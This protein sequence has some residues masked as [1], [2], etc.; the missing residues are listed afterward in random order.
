MLCRMLAPPATTVPI[1]LNADVPDRA[2]TAAFQAAG[3]AA[4]V[5]IYL[6]CLRP[7]DRGCDWG[8]R[9]GGGPRVA[10]HRCQCDRRGGLL[11]VV[12]HGR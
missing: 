1:V 7:G 11:R 4:L 3:G 12:G 8:D 5:A 10:R 6:A 2:R 9:D